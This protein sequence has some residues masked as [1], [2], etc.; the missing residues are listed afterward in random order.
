MQVK[1]LISIINDYDAKV[2]FDTPEVVAA[3]IQKGDSPLYF[4]P[5]EGK[6]RNQY[7]KS[8]NKKEFKST[9]AV[10]HVPDL[11]IKEL[12]NIFEC[13][14]TGIHDYTNKKIEPYCQ[15][16]T[17][18][19][20]VYTIFLFLHEIGHWMQFEKMDKK[21]DDY[22]NKDIELQK[23]NYQK[24]CELYKQRQERISRGIECPITAKERKLLKQYMEEYRDIPKE[25][26]ADRFA[27]IELERVLDLYKQKKAEQ[28]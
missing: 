21:V 26:E 1:E 17:S 13:D 16:G 22:I 2:I 7:E 27:I 4:T 8:K 6:E 10:I 9:S 24:I 23:E 3:R 25:K 28:V 14:A 11:S 19:D 5:V 15:S 12:V 18:I 20:V